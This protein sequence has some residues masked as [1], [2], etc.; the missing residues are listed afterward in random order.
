[1]ISAV[2]VECFCLNPCWCSDWLMLLVMSG[3]MVFSSVLAIGERRDI[4]WYDEPST[5]SLF[6]L[7]M[8]MILASFEI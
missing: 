8:G 3:R 7:G 4:E 2:V 6:D 1:M 5:G